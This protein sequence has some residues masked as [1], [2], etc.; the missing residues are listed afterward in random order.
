MQNNEYLT[1]SVA[2]LAR[3][4]ERVQVSGKFMRLDFVNG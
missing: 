2:V 3:T 4:A 1:F